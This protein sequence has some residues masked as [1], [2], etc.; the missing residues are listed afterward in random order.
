VR[1]WSG[2][3]LLLVLPLADD[4]GCQRPMSMYAGA[5]VVTLKEAR[6]AG[7]GHDSPRALT[8]ESSGSPLII[9]F[10]RSTV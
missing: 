8:F 5:H 3:C 9:S 7:L 2:L 10:E 4:C 1:K 6:L